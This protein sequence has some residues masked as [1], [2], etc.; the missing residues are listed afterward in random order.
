MNG[1]EGLESSDVDKKN[2]DA[3]SKELN[4]MGFSPVFFCF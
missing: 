4:F 1:A 3:Y 2:L